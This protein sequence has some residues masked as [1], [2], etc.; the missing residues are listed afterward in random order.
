MLLVLNPKNQQLRV[1]G[2]DALMW[3]WGKQTP[4]SL[5]GQECS[6]RMKWNTR[7]LLCR[8]HA[9]TRSQTGS[10][11]D[12]RIWRMEN[13]ARSWP[14]VETTHS[15]KAWSKRFRPIEGSAISG[16]FPGGSAAKT[17]CSQCRASLSPAHCPN[18]GIQSVSLRSPALAGRFFATSPTWEALPGGSDGI[19]SAWNAGE[20]G[21]ILGREDSPGEGNGYLLQSS[22]L[23]NPMNRGAWWATVDGVPKSQTRLIH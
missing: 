3:C 6:V 22:C 1:W 18:P 20:P 14:V 4:T 5:R 9:W 2:K 10:L 15:M 11:T 17:L 7:S 21:S 23:E 19:E 12:G 8:T 13:K 16:D